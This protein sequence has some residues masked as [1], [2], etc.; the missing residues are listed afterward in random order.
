LKFNPKRILS[1]SAWSIAGL[2]L[3]NVVAQFLV[4]PVWNRQFG[5]ETYGDI[6][7]LLSVMNIVAISMGSNCNYARITENRKGHTSAAPVLAALWLVTLAIPIIVLVLSIYGGVKMSVIEWVLFGLLMIVTMWRFYA[8]VEYRMNLDYKGCFFYYLVISIGY[9]IGIVL[10]NLTGY[11]PLALLPGEILGLLFVGIKGN[12]LVWDG[13]PERKECRAVWRVIITLVITGV[14]SN[15]IYNAD[16]LLLKAL[17]GGEEVTIYYLASLLGKTMTLVTT[18]LNSVI[19]GYLVRMDNKLDVKFMN[20]TTA[21]VVGATVLGTAAC[22]LGS[23]ILIP[24]LYPVEYPIAQSYFLIGNLAQI[25]YFISG[26]VTVVLLRYCSSRYQ[27]YVNVAYA[28]AFVGICI[29]MTLGGSLSNFCIGLLLTSICRILT[30][31][32]LGYKDAIFV[33]KQ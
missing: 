28:I 30:A 6:L 8:D 32:V 23:Y 20:I 14:I 12:C 2:V 29:P 3:M 21:F 17:A 5:S 1:D 18:P 4:Y 9:G 31:L 7:Y 13:F 27:L 26:V 10:S 33:K 24:L 16:R 25:I 15:T 19:I 22:T 11:W